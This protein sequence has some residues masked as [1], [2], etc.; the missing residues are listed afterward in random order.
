MA[1]LGE[2][3]VTSRSV[4]TRLHGDTVTRRQGPKKEA[5][6]KREKNET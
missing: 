6:E 2:A 1:L 3:S 4:R 5:V